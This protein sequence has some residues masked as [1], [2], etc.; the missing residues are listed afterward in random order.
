MVAL[1]VTV[2]FCF[3]HNM[4]LN[5]PQ[6]KGPKEQERE[7]RVLNNCLTCQLY[8]LG[9]NNLFKYIFYTLQV[10]TV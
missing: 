9:H 6:N 2:I 4:S 7:I 1:V 3:T 8:E 5:M 10:S